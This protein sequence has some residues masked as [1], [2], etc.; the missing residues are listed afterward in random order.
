MLSLM[1]LLL[2]MKKL[3][4]VYLHAASV[5]LFGLAHLISIQYIEREI[6]SDMEF[7][8]LDDFVKLERHGYT[9]IAQVSLLAPL[10]DCL[11]R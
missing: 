8:V 6:K 4:N 5:L 3:V 1:I 2:P 7:V 10:L 9:F 11:F